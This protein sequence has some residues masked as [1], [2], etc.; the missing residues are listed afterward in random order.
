MHSGEFIRIISLRNVSAYD[1]SIHSPVSTWDEQCEKGDSAALQENESYS[2]LMA[3]MQI[4]N[5]D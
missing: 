2:A 4:A 5:Y 3:L 1:I